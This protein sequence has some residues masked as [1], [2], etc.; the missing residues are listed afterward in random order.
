[1]VWDLPTRAF[2]WLLTATFVGAIG[3]ALIADDKSHLF[4][5]HMLLGLIPV[6]LVVLRVIWGFVG[7]RYARLGSFLFTLIRKIT[8]ETRAGRLWEILR[9]VTLVVGNTAC[10]VAF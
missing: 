8:S 6:F 5:T 9:G 7:T 10:L 4:Q 2:Y 3:I 1:M